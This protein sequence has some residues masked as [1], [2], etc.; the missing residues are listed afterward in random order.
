MH[1]PSKSHLDAVYRILEYLK[2]TLGRGL[3]FQ[4]NEERKAEVYVDADWEGSV[5]NR[6]ST[7]GYCSY[8]WG[9]LVTWRS[10]KQTVVARS[11]AKAELR[12]VRSY[13]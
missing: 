8:V 1:S 11:S 4:K 5:T 12:S 13:G 2:G 6:Q 9:N 7:S 3:L 10:K